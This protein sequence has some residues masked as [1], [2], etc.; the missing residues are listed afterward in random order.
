M[1][2]TTT[3]AGYVGQ[4]L[5]RRE[6]RRHLI[7]AARFLP[8]LQVPGT[9]QVA[10]VRSPHGHARVRGLD[11]SAALRLPGVAGVLTAAEARA[12]ARPFSA[13]VDMPGLRPLEWYPLAEDVVRYVG[14]PLAAVAATDRYLAEDAAEL[15]AVAYE[16]LPAVASVEAALAA[17]A[18]RLYPAWDDNVYLRRTFANGDVDAALARAD[19]VVRERFE[20]Q[21]YSGVPL[22]GRGCL[23]EF[24]AGTGRLTVWSSTQWPHALRTVLADLLD[25]PESRVRVVAPDVGGG[26]GNK[27]HVF[28]EELAVCLLALTLR[29]PVQWIEDRQENLKASVHARQ[30]V[31]EVE[32]AVRRDGVLL[33]LR[34]RVTADMGSGTMYFSGLAPQL[35]TVGSVP[36]PYRLQDY[37]YDLR[38]V[39]TNKCPAGAYRGFGRANAVFTMERVMDLIARDTGLDPAEVRR[40]N[41]LRPDELPYET[42]PGGV[43]DSG[44]YAECLDEALRL[45]EYDHWRAAQ[46]GLRAAGR[47]VGVGIACFVEGTAANIRRSAGRWGPYEAA[48]A[49]LE[50]DGRLAL[51]VGLSPHGQGLETSL[52]QVAADHLGITP[53]EVEVYHGD[54]ASCPYGLGTWSSRSAV[55]GGVV[56]GR[57]VGQVR[58]KALRIAAALLEAA[59]DD[60]AIGAGAVRVRG[61][62]SRAVPLRDVAAVAYHATHLLPPGLEPGLQATSWY[63]PPNTAGIPDARGRVNGNATFS[64]AT[65]VAVVEVA[66]ATGEVRILRYAVAHD[67]GTVINPLIVEGQIHGGVA[68]G[69]GGALYEEFVYDEAGQCLTG[70][71]LD[72]LIPTACELP[73][74]HLGHLVTP[75]PFVEGGYKGM[76]EGGALGPPAA[77]AN[78]VADALAPFGARVTRTPLTPARILALLD[79]AP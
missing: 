4:R 26:F 21:R 47:L 60:L 29:Q 78:A 79:G 56:V 73:G 19:L 42:A 70:S 43:L 35:V 71:L 51:Y 38:C 54:T 28:R 58:D 55:V 64:N 69:I 32:A 65:H 18:P 74:L 48:T 7:G 3:P 36:G 1:T 68:Q 14:E 25:L 15:I 6:D 44:R 2:T 22:E 61:Q 75:S 13:N 40:R 33:G 49:R 72:Y 9:L 67:C 11:A 77:L 66:P 24:D 50:P 23:A 63:E 34:V 10:F 8:D 16:P 57:A 52:A 76:G 20:A 41:L 62:A 59:P 39:V 37:A 17:D 45:A 27:Q 46:P 5:R 31:H 30:Q 12:R 53:D